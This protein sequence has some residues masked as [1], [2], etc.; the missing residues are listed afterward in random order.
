MTSRDDTVKNADSA[1][2]STDSKPNTV[3][4]PGLGELPAPGCIDGST[5][6]LD[7]SCPV[8][9]CPASFNTRPTFRQMQGHFGKTIAEGGPSAKAHAEF[10]LTKSDY[11]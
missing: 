2:A 7:P 6:R 10:D 11:K 1:S 5:V 4:I 9:G 8:P 3:S